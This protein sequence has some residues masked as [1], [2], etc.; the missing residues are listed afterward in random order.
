MSK[1]CII[2]LGNMGEAIVNVLLRTGTPK[3]HITGIE[4]R[5]DR[6]AYMLDRYAISVSA[7]L[8]TSSDDIDYFIL[9]V[10]PQD[11]RKILQTMAGILR[12][13]QICVSIMAG[14]TI[15]NILS[16][17]GK[18]AKVVRAMPNIA[19]KVAKGAIGITFND[20]VST[21]DKKNV[22]EL[23]STLGTVVEV[24]EE[25]MDAVT[26]LGG[27]GPG[28]FLLFLEAMIDGGVKMG[29]S[30]DKARALTLQVVQGISAMLEEENHH[31]T[32][33]RE[34][35]TSPGG[36]TIAGLAVLEERAFKGSVMR[37]LEEAKKRA[38]E[39]SL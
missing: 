17:L 27:S 16:V 24:D 31:L 38:K 12:A 22:I 7:D 5:E 25:M 36:T 19:V 26:A 29:L 34:I 37:A 21:N 2:G 6:Q 3:E 10:K 35:I 23:F 4:A 8:A 9:A 15:G 18:P 13:D 33:L 28:F 39:L 20:F 30:R 32:V 11:S 14:I 1:I